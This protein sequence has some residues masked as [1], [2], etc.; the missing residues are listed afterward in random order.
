MLTT[1]KFHHDKSYNDPRQCRQLLYF[2][3]AEK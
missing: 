1:N 2:T 3:Y